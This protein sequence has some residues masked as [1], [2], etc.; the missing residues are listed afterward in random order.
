MLAPRTPPQNGIIERRN[1][2][3]MECARI[4]MMEKKVSKKYL[5]EVVSTIVYT[6]NKVKVKKGINA[7]PYELWYGYSHNVKY[8]KIFSSRLYILKDNRNGKLDD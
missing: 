5:R 3:I 2:S 6:L 1:R 4:L 8:F 7:T